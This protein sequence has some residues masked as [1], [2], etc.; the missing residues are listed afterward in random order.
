MKTETAE[1]GEDPT[2]YITIA[3]TILNV[4]MKNNKKFL[5]FRLGIFLA[6]AYA[7]LSSVLKSIETVITEFITIVTPSRPRISPVYVQY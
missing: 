3:K 1:S 5:S 6:D 2:R 4:I 7:S